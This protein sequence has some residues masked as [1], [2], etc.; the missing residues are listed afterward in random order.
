MFQQVLL[1]D[2][3]GRLIVYFRAVSYKKN[4]VSGDCCEM[5]SFNDYA[6]QEFII[7]QPRGK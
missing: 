3:M 6:A 4:E 1:E 2:S 7:G 5:Y